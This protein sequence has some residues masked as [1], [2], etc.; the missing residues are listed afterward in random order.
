[1]RTIFYVLACALLASPALAQTVK[2]QPLPPSGAPQ[3]DLKTGRGPI[4]PG[5]KKPLLKTKDERWN[6]LLTAAATIAREGVDV[7]RI[8]A[9]ERKQIDDYVAE[10]RKFIAGS[11]QGGITEAEEDQIDSNIAGMYRAI[12]GYMTN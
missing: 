11:R 10:A 8:N 1:M 5:Q 6:R 12:A 9:Q 7:G 4:A 3:Q 2:P